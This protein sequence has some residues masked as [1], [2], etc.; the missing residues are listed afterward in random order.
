MS[1][2]QEV[3]WGRGKKDAKEK[4]KCAGGDGSG[5]GGRVKLM[6]DADLSWRRQ[7]REEIS[8]CRASPQ[9]PTKC[10]QKERLRSAFPHSPPTSG[11]GGGDMEGS[12]VV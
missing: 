3:G 6:I 9:V 10:S 2:K 4:K 11:W 7:E 12:D 5:G 8:D 1:E